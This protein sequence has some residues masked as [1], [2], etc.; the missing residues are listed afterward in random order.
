MSGWYPQ[1]HVSHRARITTQQATKR[2]PFLEGDYEDAW[3]VTFYLKKALR[4]RGRDEQHEG[5]RVRDDSDEVC[6][7]T[8]TRRKYLSRL[9]GTQADYLYDGPPLRTRGRREVHTRASRK[10]KNLTRHTPVRTTSTPASVTAP[11]VP[12]SQVRRREV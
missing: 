9:I 10:S 1:Y 11:E 6:V 2:L 7:R 4:N 3:P 12:V 5:R 8:S